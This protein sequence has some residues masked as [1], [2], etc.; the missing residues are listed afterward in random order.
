MIEERYAKQLSALAKALG[1]NAIFLARRW[2]TGR[3]VMGTDTGRS[4]HEDERLEDFTR[5]HD[6]QRQG[7]DRHDIDADDAVFGIQPA[8][9]KLLTIQT[10]KA[11]PEQAR[12]GNRGLNGPQRFDAG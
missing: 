8:Y 4:I 3:M 9:E 12:G 2:I 11:G 1:E 7:A 5:M 6:N 10:F